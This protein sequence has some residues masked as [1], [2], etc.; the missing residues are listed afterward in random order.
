LG[1]FVCGGRRRRRG[2]GRTQA[3]LGP[4]GRLASCAAL[5]CIISKAQLQ[6]LGRLLLVLCSL[7]RRRQDGWRLLAVPFIV[8]K[9]ERGLLAQ[10]ALPRH[11]GGMPPSRA[12]R[13]REGRRR[14]ARSRET[15]ATPPLP[16]LPAAAGCCSA[17]AGAG[18]WRSLSLQSA[19][20]Q[21]VVPSRAPSKQCPHRPSSFSAWRR[22]STPCHLTG[23]LLITAGWLQWREKACSALMHAASGASHA[24]CSW[25]PIPQPHKL[26]IFPEHIWHTRGL[27]VSLD[28]RDANS[29]ARNTCLPPQTPCGTRIKTAG[30]LLTSPEAPTKQPAGA[31]SVARPSRRRRRQPAEQAWVLQPPHKRRRQS[32]SSPHSSSSSS[33]AAA[34]SGRAKARRHPRYRA[35]FPVPSC[36]QLC[37][38]LT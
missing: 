21:Q 7:G 23:A 6:L 1:P 30:R 25:Q 29:L 36:R 13:G 34:G 20:Q 32:R 17:Q 27:C 14:E 24:W 22:T 38:R 19:L 15:A 8:V 35:S 16:S 31:A 10:V 4:P 11:A 26:C 37:S 12:L 5:I 3:R 18:S 9:A 2:A 33:M 28:S